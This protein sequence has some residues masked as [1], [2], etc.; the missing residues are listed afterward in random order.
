MKTYAVDLSVNGRS[1]AEIVQARSAGDAIAIAKMK[2]PEAAV[3]GARV[4]G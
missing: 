3:F 1:F 2:W 4:I